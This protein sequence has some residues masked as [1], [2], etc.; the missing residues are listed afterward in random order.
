MPGCAVRAF[1]MYLN[2]LYDSYSNTIYFLGKQMLEQ[3]L[4]SVAFYSNLYNL[5]EFSASLKQYICKS[6]RTLL[7]RNQVERLH[8]ESEFSAQS[9]GP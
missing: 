6:M 3:I 5:N 2:M 7:S 9:L 8:H 4:F 1:E